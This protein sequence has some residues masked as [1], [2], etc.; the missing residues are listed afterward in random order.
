MNRHAAGKPASVEDAAGVRKLLAACVDPYGLVPGLLLVDVAG[1][2]LTGAAAALLLA[3][4][5]GSLSQLTG[6]FLSSCALF[7]AIPLVSQ[8]AAARLMYRR[9]Q[10]PGC[11]WTV[12]VNG[13]PAAFIEDDELAWL[14]L[15]VLGDPRARTR[16]WL[17]FFGFVLRVV[18][19]LVQMLP[20]FAIWLAVGLL[21]F[22]P[23]SFEALRSL[24]AGQWRPL[25]ER[26]ALTAPLVLL[27]ALA[28]SSLRAMVTAPDSV[29]VAETLRRLAE[30]LRLEPE[31]R[32]D[33][34]AP[35]PGEVVE[36]SELPL[37]QVPKE[38]AA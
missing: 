6:V 15:M 19:S 5:A 3:V 38:T 7:M 25:I 11:A 33:L 14:Q 35:C 29:F 4:C 24:S 36:G 31:A 2:V 13:R 12:R 26:M 17:V 28:I 16:C 1:V 20:A 37:I 8:A 21:V 27:I 10:Q 22:D 34:Q 18:G 23:V 32:L 30:L 9:I